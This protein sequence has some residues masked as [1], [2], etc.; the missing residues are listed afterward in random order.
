MHP[1]GGGGTV[2]MQAALLRTWKVVAADPIPARGTYYD[3]QKWPAYACR[4]QLSRSACPLL[5]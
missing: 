3:T 5:P 1:L 4:A 2:C